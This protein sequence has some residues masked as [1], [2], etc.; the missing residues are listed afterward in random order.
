MMAIVKERGFVLGAAIAAMPLSGWLVIAL[1]ITLMF[2]VMQTA[3]LKSAKSTYASFVAQT[4]AAGKA[5][6]KQADAQRI[7]DQ[8]NKERV[9]DEY[10]RRIAAHRAELQR[11]RNY[12][13]SRSIVPAAP[14]ASSRPDL[15]CFDRA[16]FAAAGERLTAGVLGIAGKGT[17]DTIGLDAGK[18]AV[19]R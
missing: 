13:A 4:A 1:A 8:R 3:R 12:Y 14:A 2:G 10:T 11:V 17:E 7:A 19:Q 5:A 6:Q 16:L 15:A 18:R 9:D